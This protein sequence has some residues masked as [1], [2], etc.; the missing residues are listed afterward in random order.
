MSLSISQTAAIK[1]R[2]PTWQ[3][4]GRRALPR[5]HGPLPTTAGSCPQRN[6]GIP[7]SQGADF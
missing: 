7:L 5:A 6:A 3:R 4:Q 1:A 2:Q